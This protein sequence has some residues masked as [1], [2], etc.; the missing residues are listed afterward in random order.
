M[1]A[2]RL[3]RG[4]KETCYKLFMESI[5]ADINANS[6]DGKQYTESDLHSGFTYYKQLKTKMG[7]EGRVKVE[8]TE[9]VP[10]E[11]YV[12]KFFSA[13]GVNTVSY[14]LEDEDEDL[15]ALTYEE[16]F[17]SDKTSKNLNF[18]LMNKLFSRSSKKKMDLMFNQLQTLLDSKE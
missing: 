13:Q 15:F 8:L 3:M 7:Q 12:A 11:V 6:E 10:N 4:K 18:S 14:H 5:L 17:I 2:T 1:E 9:L 16:D